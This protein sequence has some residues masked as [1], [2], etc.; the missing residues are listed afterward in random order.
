MPAVRERLLH[1]GG[2]RAL[3]LDEAGALLL[4]LG[5]P[6]DGRIEELVERRAA[7]VRSRSRHTWTAPGG[8][9]CDAVGSA[10]TITRRTADLRDE[11]AALWQCAVQ[12][13]HVARDRLVERYIRLAYM[14]ARRY[15]H[16]SEP[17]EDLEQVACVGLLHA[18]DRFD[19]G[20]GTSFSTFAVP[21]IL[22]ELRRHFRDRTW[23]VR[24]PRDVRDAVTAV[25]RASEALAGPLGRSPSAAEV[26]EATGLADE[27][28]VEARAAA[29]AYRCDSLDRPAHDDDHDGATLGDRIGR[30]DEALRRAEDCILVE[31]LAAAALSERDRLVVRLRFQEDMLQREI[32]A[33]VGLSQ[34]Q[35]SRILRDS[36]QRLQTSARRR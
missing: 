20:R 28:V 19:P 10:T 8:G 33:R 18:V 26:A 29:L 6:V 22:G 36:L 2:Q 23:S 7:T 17:L 14:L 25:E 21:T 30:A 16:T 5:C 35:V 27:Q 34:M 15:S 32:A 4:H 12:G 3:S 13:D 11:E 1:L 31:Q 9:N 24:V